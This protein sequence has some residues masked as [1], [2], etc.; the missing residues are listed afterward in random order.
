MILPEELLRLK[1]LNNMRRFVLLVFILSYSFYSSQLKV[2]END[3]P[4]MI[5][6]GKVGPMGMTNIL[7]KKTEDGKIYCFDYQDTKFTHI[8]TWK[9]FCFIN[10]NDDINN[11]YKIIIEGFE[12]NADDKIKLESQ[13]HFVTLHFEKQLGVMNFWF[14]AED[15][16]T[17]VT[18]YSRYL[19]KKQIQ[20]LFGFK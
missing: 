1:K 20:K 14:D 7:L 8:V 3:T 5:E 6:V 12:K 19:S 9:D 10:E 4:K 2:V 16:N 11:L 15:K 17:G 13:F 18:G